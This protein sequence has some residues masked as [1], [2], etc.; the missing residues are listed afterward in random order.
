M[1]RISKIFL[2]FLNAITTIE[3]KNTILWNCSYIKIRFTLRNTIVLYR[4][5][6]KN[7]IVIDYVSF[8]FGI[9]LYS[10]VKDNND[11]DND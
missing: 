6:A 10:N 9:H 1:N 7:I 5:A 2:L 3:A 8:T 11:S 4:K